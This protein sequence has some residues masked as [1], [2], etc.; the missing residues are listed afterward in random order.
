[1]TLLL[2][3]VVA[4]VLLLAGACSSASVLEAGS[5]DASSE[6]GLA[7]ALIP[8]D[9]I[10]DLELYVDFLDR[11][12]DASW[13]G[14][15]ADD[16]PYAF[17]TNRDHRFSL[18]ASIEAFSGREAFRSRYGDAFGYDVED[19]SFVMSSGSAGETMHVTV[20]NIDRAAVERAID[21]DPVWAV[22]V[23]PASAAGAEYWQWGDELRLELGRNPGRPLGRGGQ[24]F[25]D[26]RVAVRT[27]ETDRMEAALAARETGRGLTVL[28]DV[29]GLIAR[30]EAE[31]FLSAYVTNKTVDPF[32]GLLPDSA[33]TA[34]ERP[35]DGGLVPYRFLAVG[36]IDDGD[37]PV[38]AAVLEHATAEMAA[39][40]GER[41]RSTVANGISFANGRPWTDVVGEVTIELDGPTL[42]A[43]FDGDNPGILFETIVRADA[44]FA[45]GPAG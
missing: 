13:W 29:S 28:D 18:L 31:R 2:R 25:V 38:A 9:D 42:V 26:G 19:A 35:T 44:L 15:E 32:D 27:V 6:V 16:L 11:A 30:L 7:L 4:T 23:S 37:G 1:M 24:L 41:L 43:R 20:G 33:A 36:T 12:R 10:D 14:D 5:D 8:A 40:N 21:A 34:G 45:V 22:E 17:L 39:E 3:F